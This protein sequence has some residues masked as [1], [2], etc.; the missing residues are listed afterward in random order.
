VASETG[1][2]LKDFIVV[3]LDDIKFL[4]LCMITH[5]S[6]QSLRQ[7]FGMDWIYVS[8]P[9]VLLEFETNVHLYSYSWPL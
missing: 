8:N 1:L 5:A 9:Y 7:V 2:W 6:V 3:M 4:L